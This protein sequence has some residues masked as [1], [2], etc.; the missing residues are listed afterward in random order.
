MIT[1]EEEKAAWVTFAA[2]AL[3]GCIPQ[4]S[5][6]VYSESV[7]SHAARFA[8]MMVEQMI[9]RYSK[10]V[11]KKEVP[12]DKYGYRHPPY[13]LGFPANKDLR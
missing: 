8:D 2:Q 1:K 7:C 6:G 12:R 3:N 5:G 10:P 11:E 13:S 9:A 4:L